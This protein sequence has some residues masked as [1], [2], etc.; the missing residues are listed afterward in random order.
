[1]GGGVL[2]GRSHSQSRQESDRCLVHCQ[3]CDRNWYRSSVWPVVLYPAPSHPGTL[4]ITLCGF[5][6]VCVA[7]LVI[8]YDTYRSALHNPAWQLSVSARQVSPFGSFSF[9]FWSEAVRCTKSP[10]SHALAIGSKKISTSYLLVEVNNR[11]TFACV[12]TYLVFEGL[13][14]IQCLRA[15]IRDEYGLLANQVL[16]HSRM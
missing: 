13:N 1:M 6:F 16:C 10:P 11:F 9:S 2:E 15:G 4:I 5:C 14:F 7:G 3:R 8:R 12:P